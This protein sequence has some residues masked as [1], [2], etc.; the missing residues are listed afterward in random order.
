MVKRIEIQNV[1]GHIQSM[2]TGTIVKVMIV[3][4]LVLLA[5]IKFN[6]NARQIV[7]KTLYVLGGIIS[8]FGTVGTT[9]VLIYK[10]LK[11]KD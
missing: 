10:Q 2:N 7:I 11:A 6:Q 5:Q 4:W 3:F 1:N 9:G 8:V